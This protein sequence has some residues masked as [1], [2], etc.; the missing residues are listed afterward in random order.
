MN[1]ESRIEL[2]ANFLNALDA[3]AMDPDMIAI[4]IEGDDKYYLKKTKYNI[5]IRSDES[6]TW[7]AY[8]RIP[9]PGDDSYRQ[10]LCQKYLDLVENS[11]P[12]H[13]DALKE[14]N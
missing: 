7:L 8:V 5:E 9:A 6:T 13:F 1:A 3:L 10:H 11:N 2:S 14:N 12:N 4:Q